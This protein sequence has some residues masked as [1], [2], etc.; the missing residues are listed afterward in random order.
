MEY[1]QAI[2]I[3]LKMLDT[4]SLTDEEKE[5]VTL[6]IGTLDCGK[7]AKNRFDGIMKTMKAKRDK[8]RMI[9]TI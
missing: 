1:K 8:K 3:L 2:D 7:L 5:A 9:D 6:A 4:H